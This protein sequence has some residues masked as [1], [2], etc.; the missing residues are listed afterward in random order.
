MLPGLAFRLVGAPHVTAAAIIVDGELVNESAERVE[1]LVA[2]MHVSPSDDLTLK[3][4]TDLPPRPPPVPPP[5]D[6]YALAPGETVSFGAALPLSEYTWPS[7][8][9]VELEWSF[10][11]AESPRPSG[12]VRVTLP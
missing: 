7:G 9:D 4:R 11:L 10:A 12:R 1:V 6:R 5:L 3:R 8:A 2:G